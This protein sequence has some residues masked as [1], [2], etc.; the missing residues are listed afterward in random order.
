MNDIERAEADEL[1]RQL[2]EAEQRADAWKARAQAEGMNVI[3]LRDQTK[4]AVEALQ[5]IARGTLRAGTGSRAYSRDELRRIA[6]D[7]LAAMRGR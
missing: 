4:G 1:R 3:R 2:R 6:A 7:A 5:E